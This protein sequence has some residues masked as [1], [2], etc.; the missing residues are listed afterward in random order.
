MEFEKI[1]NAKRLKLMGIIYISISFIYIIHINFFGGFPEESLTSRFLLSYYPEIGLQYHM[2]L[3]WFLPIWIVQMI[4]YITD[5]EFKNSYDNILKTKI[6]IKKYFWK[7][8]KISFLF[9]F[10]S[11]YALMLLTAMF[12]YVICVFFVGDLDSYANGLEITVKSG[13][14]TYLEAMHPFLAI[15]IEYFLASIIVG[16]LAATINAIH[17]LTKD[18]RVTMALG[19]LFWYIFIVMK[20]FNI[21]TA[22]QLFNLFEYD[23]VYKISTYALFTGISILIIS[24]IYKIISRQDNVK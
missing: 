2:I 12:S 5:Y 20:Q 6:G 10:I 9:T 14:F 15:I 22:L 13:I 7:K 3:I 24:L 4:T 18:L 19:M 11:F 17:F 21:M 23:I 8:T 16:I 1:K